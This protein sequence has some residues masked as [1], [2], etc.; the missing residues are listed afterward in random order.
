VNRALLITIGLTFLLLLE[1]L[2]VATALLSGSTVMAVVVAL[3]APVLVWA[4]ST[5]ASHNHSSPGMD[6]VMRASCIEERRETTMT[7]GWGEASAR[8]DQ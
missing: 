3:P 1:P 8:F 2:A 4:F 7:P 5:S 6:G